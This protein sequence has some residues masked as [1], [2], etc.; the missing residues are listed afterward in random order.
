MSHSSQFADPPGSAEKRA[1]PAPASA[2][3]A[4][5]GPHLPLEFPVIVRYEQENGEAIRL[6]T[7]TVS[8]AVNGALLLLPAPLPQNHAIRLVNVK[9][10]QEIEC[11]VRSVREKNGQYHAG[12]EFAAWCPDFWE[13]TFPRE[14]GD[15]AP[16]PPPDQRP[17]RPF[18][19][20][21]RIAPGPLPAQADLP[22]QA[23][24]HKLLRR[25]VLFGWRKYL[26][27]P[28]PVLLLAAVWLALRPA[29]GNAP[30][31]PP[32]APLPGELLQIVPG[33]AGFRLAAATDFAIQASA[34]L[35]QLGQ[36]VSG[37]IPG[38]FTPAGQSTAYLL[39]N[40]EPSWRVLIVENGQLRC[41]ARYKS[42][43]IAGRIPHDLLPRI[44]WLDRSPA[45]PSGDGLLLVRS[46][47]QKDSALV[48]FLQG[49][50]VLS[51]VPADYEE[52]PL[53]QDRSP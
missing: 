20:R 23:A 21:E 6:H 45:Q 12:V 46:A 40:S 9:T 36:P 26:L 47:S 52:I 31:A 29:S 22:L 53:L 10:T 3:S 48:L 13:I 8:V 17:S 44:H 34:F 32:P 24:S 28:L 11:I 38:Q 15:P 18:F 42:I 39:V 2:P 49:T 25:L 43:A 5:K 19:G 14:Q 30:P 37:K 16:E 50:D 1:E 7:R 4:R 51:A 41:D 35:H 27:L 33:I